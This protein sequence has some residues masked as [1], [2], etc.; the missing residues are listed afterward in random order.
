MR[1][2]QQRLER[3]R[4][5]LVS[6]AGYALAIALVDNFKHSAFRVII[7]HRR[8]IGMQEPGNS[9]RGHSKCY[10]PVMAGDSVVLPRPE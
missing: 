7:R 1:N 8:P 6:D 3:W 5:K 10:G 2:L 4:R 9:I